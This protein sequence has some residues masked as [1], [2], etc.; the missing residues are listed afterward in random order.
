MS[1]PQGFRGLGIGKNYYPFSSSG[2]RKVS[3][4]FTPQVIRLIQKRNIQLRK[5]LLIKRPSR[6]SL[7]NSMGSSGWII[8]GAPN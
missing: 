3:P 1:P 7:G 6:T 8:A 4:N 2:A 5:N